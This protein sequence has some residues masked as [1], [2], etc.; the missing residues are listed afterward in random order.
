[1]L[2]K[3]IIPCLDIKEGRV[4]KGT[5]FINLRDAGDPV[6]LAQRYNKDG[7]DELVFL[8][9]TASQEK[10]ETLKTL[11]RSVASQVN[12]PFTVGG[13]IKSVED[14]R[15]V[16][17]NGA[18]K[19]SLNTAAVENPKIITKIAD[20]FGTQC[21]VVAIDAKRRFDNLDG[22]QLAQTSKDPCWFEVYTY[23]GR[24][25]TGIDAL[26]WATKAVKLGAGEL[27][28]TSM[29]RDGTKKGYDNLL[30]NAISEK[31]KVPLIASGGAGE[32]KHF[33]DAFCEGKADAALAASVFHY[34]QY[35]IPIVKQYLIRMGV[36]IRV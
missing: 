23:G 6:E 35:P 30:N 8:D 7:A 31:V 32:P 24:T 11:V 22:H 34:N 2:T 13:G 17:R 16:L 20:M 1:M 12:I 26:D 3:R 9:I 10:R 33:L 21:V 5:H 29:D 28:V 19:I 18:D 25:S 15:T 27:L 14:V 36:N 4:V